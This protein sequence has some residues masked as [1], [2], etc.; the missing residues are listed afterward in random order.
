MVRAGE[1]RGMFFFCLQTYKII[2]G[3]QNFLFICC[4]L[5]SKDSNSTKDKSQLC[6]AVKMTLMTHA[7]QR[8]ASFQ[9]SID[10]YTKD[11]QSMV[12]IPSIQNVWHWQHLLA[13]TRAGF[14]KGLLNSTWPFLSAHLFNPQKC[15]LSLLRDR[16]AHTTVG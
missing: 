2:V 8:V 3:F 6:R 9:T 4:F 15:C 5:R 1:G 14:R 13:S 7:P 12:N 16:P 11:N 10:L